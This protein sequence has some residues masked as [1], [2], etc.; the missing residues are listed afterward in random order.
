VKLL[1][2]TCECTYDEAQL[3]EAG[4]EIKVSFTAV[5]QRNLGNTIPR[6]LATK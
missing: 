5:D 4:I 2:R 3:K 1:I 6:W